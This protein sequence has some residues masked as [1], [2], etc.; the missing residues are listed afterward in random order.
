MVRAAGTPRDRLIVRSLPETG[1]RLG[2][3]TGL[4]VGDLVTHDG[5][6]IH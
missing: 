3:L 4:R 1:C 6:A 5:S 2:E